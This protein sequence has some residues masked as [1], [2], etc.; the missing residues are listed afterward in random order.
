M[1]PQL[2]TLQEIIRDKPATIRGLMEVNFSDTKAAIVSIITKYGLQL[3][4]YLH[5]TQEQVIGSTDIILSDYKQL[6]IE[7]VELCI[8]NGIKGL[9]GDIMRFDTSVIC[10]WLTKY[11]E[12]KRLAAMN[13]KE[14]K[15]L[16]LMGQGDPMPDHVKEG[17][18]NLFKKHGVK[19]P[20]AKEKKNV[21]EYVWPI[22]KDDF[23]K[24]VLVHF[25]ELW[26]KQGSKTFSSLDLTPWAFYG[27]PKQGFSPDSFLTMSYDLKNEMRA[28]ND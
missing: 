20:F 11:M 12:E 22:P 26:E 3:A 19:E 27:N 25:N 15:P 16:R 13:I 8:R 24:E 21:K 7:D 23:E 4:A 6:S 28:N 2:P 9:Y 14:E 10:G 1:R 18:T 5:P 17:L